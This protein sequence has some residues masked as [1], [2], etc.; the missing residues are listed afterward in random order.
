MPLMQ[1]GT[2][3]LYPLGAI[4]SEKQRG[5][6]LCACLCAKQQ[7]FFTLVFSHTTMCLFQHDVYIRYCV[8]SDSGALALPF[9]GYSKA[10]EVKQTDITAA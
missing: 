2:F 10:Q 8:A 4:A 1:D 5:D 9:C 3:K 6:S 7:T